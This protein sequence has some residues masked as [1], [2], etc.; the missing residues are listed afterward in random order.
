MYTCI[1]GFVIVSEREFRVFINFDLHRLNGFEMFLL[2]IHSNLVLNG[3]NKVFMVENIFGFVG[4]L[5]FLMD[6]AW[7]DF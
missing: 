6:E 4:G 1:C 7:L 3:F 5:N 2:N